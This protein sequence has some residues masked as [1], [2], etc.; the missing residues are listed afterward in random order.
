MFANATPEQLRQY[1]RLYDTQQRVSLS[2]GNAAGNQYA[3]QLREA[4]AA[5]RESAEQ[6]KALQ[7]QVER[8]TK[9]AEKQ[10][11]DAPERTGR[12]VG[13]EINK[14]VA[15]GYRGRR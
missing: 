4:Q 13:A 5:R 9:V 8:L 15:G 10:E 2:A 1:A 14:V 7:K 12:A 11:R 6:A 3:A